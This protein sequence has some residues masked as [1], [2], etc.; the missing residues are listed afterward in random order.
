[1]G[2]FM[3]IVTLNAIQLR[4]RTRDN[5]VLH[6]DEHVPSVNRYMSLLEDQYKDYVRKFDSSPLG[7]TL[8][9]REKIGNRVK[10]HVHIVAVW[11]LPEVVDTFV[12]GHE[13]G[14]ARDFMRESREGLIKAMAVSGVKNP[15]I[16][17]G[18]AKDE[19]RAD[20]TGFY[21]VLLK[22]GV[23]FFDKLKREARRTGVRPFCGEITEDMIVKVR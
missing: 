9:Y 8:G 12:L 11:S 3:Q 2:R 15:E 16:L 18:I 22:Y 13:A 4:E 7:A 23:K 19:T 1:M 5:I 20:I 17:L 14:H 10:V 21:A 6:Q